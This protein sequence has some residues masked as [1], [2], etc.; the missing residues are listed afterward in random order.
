MRTQRIANSGPSFLAPHGITESRVTVK[1]GKTCA[2]KFGGGGDAVTQTRITQ[3]PTIGKAGVSTHTVLYQAKAGYVGK[4]EFSY[5][6]DG[7]DATG[8][9]APMVVRL[10]VDVVQ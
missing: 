3:N 1:S 8:K 4:D 2:I 9:P 6:R 7:V 10:K 5:T